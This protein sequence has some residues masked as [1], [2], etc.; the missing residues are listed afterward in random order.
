MTPV[1]AIIID[2][3]KASV[4]ILAETL[5][6]IPDVELGGSSQNLQEGLRLIEVADP[7]IVFLDIEFPDENAMSLA[8]EIQSRGYPK[9]VFYSSYSKYLLQALRLGVFDFILKPLNPEDVELVIHKFRLGRR[10]LHAASRAPLGTTLNF[11]NQKLLAI[12]TVTGDKVIVPASSIAYFRYDNQR[13]LWEAVLRNLERFILK[14]HTNAEVILNY[15]QEFVRTHKSYII[16]TAYLGMVSQT[17]CRL[18]PPLEHITEI[19]ISKNYRRDLL[20]RFY[21]I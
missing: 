18:L 14:R 11:D 15:G 13:K 6:E 17:E 10:E 7:D 21:D 12:T 16:N 2:D 4:D 5:K 8:E 1:K 3:D 20:D 19:K 9:I